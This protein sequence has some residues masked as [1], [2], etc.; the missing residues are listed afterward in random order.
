MCTM[1]LLYMMTKN[2]RNVEADVKV[3]TKT[4]AAATKTPLTIAVTVLSNSNEPV[5]FCACHP[6]A[7][8]MLI[9]SE[10]HLY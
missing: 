4:T 5:S 3:I 7:G 6:W 8:A 2:N 9:F 1:Q 10:L